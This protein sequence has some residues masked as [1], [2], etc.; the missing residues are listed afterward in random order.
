[1]SDQ[2]VRVEKVEQPPDRYVPY[3]TM[4]LLGMRADGR[5]EVR[6]GIVLP[7]SGFKYL[8]GKDPVAGAE[9]EITMLPRG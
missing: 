9:Y 8:A 3:V 2:F 6:G 7:E 4:E 5:V 1:M